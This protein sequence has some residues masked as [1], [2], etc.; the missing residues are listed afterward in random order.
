MG[1][2]SGVT[3]M[4]GVSTGV[5]LGVTATAIKIELTGAVLVAM[6]LWINV[7]GQAAMVKWPRKMI[8]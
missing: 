7:Q 1:E 8:F 4:A 3:E 2:V 5:K 6:N